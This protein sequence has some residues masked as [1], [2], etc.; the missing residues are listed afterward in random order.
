MSQLFKSEIIPVFAGGGTRLPAY[1]GILKALEEY[2]LG[3]RHMVGTSGGSV[4]AALYCAGWSVDRLFDLAMD[5]DFAQFKGFSLPSLIRKG[6]LSSGDSF[7]RWMDE[8]LKGVTFRDLPLDLHVV[9]TDVFSQ[10]PVIFD[11]ETTPDLKVS[12]AVRFSVGIP[13]LFTYKHYGEKLL[14]DGSILAED[15]LRRDWGRDGAPLVFFRL[16]ASLTRSSQFR[17]R[18]FPLPE[19]VL[20]LIRTFL[21]SLS[22]EYVADLY[23]SKTLLVKTDDFSPLEFSLSRE[24]KD[25]LFRLG[26]QTAMDF[27]PLKLKGLI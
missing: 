15:A 20:M 14:V 18:Y 4:V 9:A 8:Q 21:T 7:E 10:E 5:I 16:R 19:Y 24:S 27:L 12:T 17:N 26:Y 22:R 6:G 2:K 11:R 3:F 23:W 1:V 25:K 13:L